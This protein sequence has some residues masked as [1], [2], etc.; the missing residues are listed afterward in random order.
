MPARAER[1]TTI[2]EGSAVNTNPAKREDVVKLARKLN[3][4]VRED[5]QPPSDDVIDALKEVHAIG[6]HETQSAIAESLASVQD[7]I[8]KERTAP[9]E[10]EDVPQGI[11]HKKKPPQPTASQLAQSK[12]TRDR[13]H[14][15]KILAT[16]KRIEATLDQI[17]ELPADELR[18]LPP[19]PT[20][21]QLAHSRRRK[22]DAM[23]REGFRPEDFRPK[24]SGIGL[25]EDAW[26]EQGERMSKK[27]TTAGRRI[28]R[29]REQNPGFFGKLSGFFKGLFKERSKEPLL[30]DLTASIAR[31]RNTADV[32]VRDMG[33]LG[34]EEVVGKGDVLNA[35]NT[36]VRSLGKE[37]MLNVRDDDERSGND[38]GR[39][40]KDV[41][42]FLWKRIV[43]SGA[44]IDLKTLKEFAKKYAEGVD[45]VMFPA[46]GS[47]KTRKKAA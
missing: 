31:G 1:M 9:R 12:A 3:V 41:Y 43:A 28:A 32:L 17:P 34:A 13:L 26:L 22:K 16:Q 15:A 40:Q 46:K 5:K 35:W 36:S 7:T 18:E 19:P 14:D 8:T 29:M 47:L 2:E 38:I 21:E 45:A 27:N 37:Y 20:G 4:R 25:A 24:N 23:I 10:V 6:P 39:T 33:E 42:D 30:S 44:H 11:R